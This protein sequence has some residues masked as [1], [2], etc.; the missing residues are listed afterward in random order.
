MLKNKTIIVDL[1]VNIIRGGPI[2]PF[3]EHK[4]RHYG[5]KEDIHM[6]F[7]NMEESGYGLNLDSLTISH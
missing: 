4:N 5:N 3:H 1:I 2:R 7:K 6:N